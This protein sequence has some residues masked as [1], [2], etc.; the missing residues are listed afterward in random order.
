MTTRAFYET[1]TIPPSNTEM[2]TKRGFRVFQRWLRSEIRLYFLRDRWKKNWDRFGLSKHLWKTLATHD[3]NG[4]ASTRTAA[5]GKGSVK[6]CVHRL[7]T[8]QSNCARHENSSDAT[9]AAVVGS[10]LL[11]AKAFLYRKRVSLRNKH[12]FCRQRDV[13]KH[14]LLPLP[15]QRAQYLHRVAILRFLRGRRELLA[16]GHVV[17]QRQA[18]AVGR[19]VCAVSKVYAANRKKGM[20]QGL[21]K[22]HSVLSIGL[23]PLGDGSVRPCWRPT[24]GNHPPL[25][26]A[27]F[28]NF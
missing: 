4:S 18:G 26:H 17:V 6:T 11:S 15:A 8:L 7:K 19:A 16:A 5:T 2:V 10:A 3:P 27:R 20:K 24:T 14:A 23:L 1:S 21:V 9:R 28:F 22:T 13:T 12:T 25:T